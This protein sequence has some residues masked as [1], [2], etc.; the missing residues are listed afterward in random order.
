MEALMIAALVLLNAH[1]TTSLVQQFRPSWYNYAVDPRSCLLI[2]IWAI[3][4]IIIV[5]LL[6]IGAYNCVPTLN[7][8]LC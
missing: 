7:S 2:P 4:V 3:A 8:K 6:I 1:M 5:A